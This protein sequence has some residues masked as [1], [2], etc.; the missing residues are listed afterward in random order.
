[1]DVRFCLVKLSIFS[2]K[3]VKNFSYNGCYSCL[4]ASLFFFCI[5]SDSF[6]R[7]IEMKALAYTLF[8][9]WENLFL[10]TSIRKEF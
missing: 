5:L 8:R 2:Q 4:P 7:R 1:M 3:V 10:L 9:S 6:L